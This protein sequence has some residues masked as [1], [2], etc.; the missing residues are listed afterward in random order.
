MKTKKN[1]RNCA[2]WIMI[3]GCVRLAQYILL[4]SGLSFSPNDTPQEKRIYNFQ[5]GKG[6][7]AKQ[8]ATP[9]QKRM[10]DS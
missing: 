4:V 2:N 9:Y 6:S 1:M 5:T 3:G 10:G 7:Q 8:N